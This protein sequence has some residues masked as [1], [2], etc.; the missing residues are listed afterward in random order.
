MANRIG[1]LVLVDADDVP[2]EKIPN[3]VG[4]GR[5]STADFVDQQV[6]SSYVEPLDREIIKTEHDFKSDISKIVQKPMPSKMVALE[7]IQYVNRYLNRLRMREDEQRESV[8]AERQPKRVPPEPIVRID[9]ESV[10]KYGEEVQPFSED[11]LTKQLE[12]RI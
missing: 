7:V 11:N 6:K 9:P 4:E 8:L 12:S 2:P 3:L 1:K 10:L 5:P